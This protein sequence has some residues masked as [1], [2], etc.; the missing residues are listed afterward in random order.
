MR[1]LLPAVFEILFIIYPLAHHAVLSLENHLS[2][3]L[4][5]FQKC[6]DQ[7]IFFYVLSDVQLPYQAESASNIQ[8][9]LQTG[10]EPMPATNLKRT[11]L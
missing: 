4:H 6:F 3:D 1:F 11:R 5:R 10:F 8:K 9:G 2:E 7:R